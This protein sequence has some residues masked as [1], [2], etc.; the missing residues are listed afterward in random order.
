LIKNKGNKNLYDTTIQSLK[1]NPIIVILIIAFLIFISIGEIFDTTSKIAECFSKPKAEKVI[2][3]EEKENTPNKKISEEIREN[4]G[5]IKK[6]GDLSQVGKKEAAA[7][8]ENNKNNSS[9]GKVTNSDKNEILSQDIIKIDKIKSKYSFI[10]V[11][12]S[13]QIS[14]KK[15]VNGK[16]ANIISGHNTSNQFVGIDR[17]NEEYII[18]TTISDYFPPCNDYEFISVDSQKVYICD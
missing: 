13:D 12:N 17:L 15:T 16:P 10:L 3:P 8:E 4:T 6:S 18:Q 2:P 14:A 9:I 11:L 7:E 5:T 1:N